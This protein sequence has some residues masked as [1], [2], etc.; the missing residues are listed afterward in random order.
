MARGATVTIDEL[1]KR[2]GRPAEAILNLQKAYP[3][4]APKSYGNLQK[5]R[6]FLLGHMTYKTATLT[7]RR[8]LG[9][10]GR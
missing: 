6:A 4:K 10:P 2:L 8:Q 3:D 9:R 1:A 7:P 5:W